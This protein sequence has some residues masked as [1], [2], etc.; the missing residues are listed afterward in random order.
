MKITVIDT[1][2]SAKETLHLPNFM[3]LH[4][5]HGE[6]NFSNWGR[7]NKPIQY[8]KIFFIRGREFFRHSCRSR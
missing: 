5:L 8:V 4:A 2:L 1:D 7:A 6:E 3:V